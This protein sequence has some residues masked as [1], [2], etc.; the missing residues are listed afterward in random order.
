MQSRAGREPSYNA[1]VAVD[2]KSRMVVGGYATNAV[3]DNGELPQLLAD[4]EANTGRN[5]ERLCADRGYSLKAGLADLKERGIEGFIPQREEVSTHFK[6]EDFSYDKETDTYR[7]PNQRELH[8]RGVANERRQSYR[9]YVCKDCGG[10]SMRRRCM[11]SGKSN[12]TLH[13]SIYSGLYYEMRERVRTKFGRI[14]ARVRASTVEPTFGHIKANRSLRQFYFRGHKMV[15]AMWKLELASHN[16]EKL[17]KL[18]MRTAP[19]S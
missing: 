10:C 6:Q 8:Y 9:R 18:R 14:M 11:G 15:D 13:V 5:P 16:I 7:C 17:I 2:V 1:Q 19:T 3:S 4:I 12:R